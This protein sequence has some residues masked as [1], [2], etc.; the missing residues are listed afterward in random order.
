MDTAN[1]ITDGSELNSKGTTTKTEIKPA[2]ETTR[3]YRTF[4]YPHIESCDKANISGNQ[5][6][7][8]NNLSPTQ[9]SYWRGKYRREHNNNNA[10]GNSSKN[11]FLGVKVSSSNKTECL[12]SL[13][14]SR[15]HRLLI[16]N[17]DCLRMLP[18][19]LSL[20]K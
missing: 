13:E 12:C 11:D 15:G 8:E 5:Y 19:I 10:G 17:T 1:S 2:T 3:K 14:F 9:F 4:W 20:I 7:R 6:C 16:H 18:Q